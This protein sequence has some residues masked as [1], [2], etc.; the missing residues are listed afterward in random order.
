MTRC[1]FG[2]AG[3]LQSSGHSDT[4]LQQDGS[5][6]NLVTLFL[7]FLGELK[8]IH[9]CEATKHPEDHFLSVNVHVEEI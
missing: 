4:W 1:S 6:H 5:G 2:R 9:S 3:D 7:H 8:D